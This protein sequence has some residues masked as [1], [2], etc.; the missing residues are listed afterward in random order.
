[1]NNT[2]K[3]DIKLLIGGD[4]APVGQ[5]ETN[6]LQKRSSLF[7][8]EL[9]ELFREYDYTI[10]NLECPL[11]LGN[12]KILKT[13]PHLK[14]HPETINDLLDLN[15]QCVTIANNHIRD[16]GNQGVHDT[17]D[18]C[19][20][21]NIDIVGAGKDADEA[22]K[23]LYK[24]LKSKTIAILNFSES[25]FNIAGKDYAGSNADEPINIYYQLKEAKSKSDFQ[26]V[27]L[28]GG[29][30]MYELPTPMQKELFRFVADLG[31]TAVIGHH[32]HVL[33]GHETI[34]KIPIIF[35]LGNFAFDDH[36]L[37]PAWNRGL[38]ASLTITQGGT[39]VYELI[40]VIQ[41]WSSG[42]V[43]LA[44]EREKAEVENSIA[45]INLKIADENSFKELWEKA[46]SSEHK[47]WLKTLFHFN[48]V[49]RF[50]FRFPLIEKFL[51]DKKHAL[52]M[53]NVMNCRTTRS[54]IIH[55]LKNSIDT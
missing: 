24:T 12:D 6:R 50:L 17:L 36:D 23:V 22:G 35:S 34:N 29:K 38:L 46:I 31:V 3:D 33:S 19:K 5:I 48:K 28:H 21:N 43:R 8:K 52:K 7:Q 54:I 47:G 45:E 27:I 32:S 10:L 18:L 39:V 30:E 44:E 15:V 51:S 37:S 49:E 4:F 55:I 26:I 9:V 14:A 53:Y 42:E 2:P 16:Y 11:T 20:K 25:E 41:D 1:M 13:G 40:P